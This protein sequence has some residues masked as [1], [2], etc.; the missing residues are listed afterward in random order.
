MSNPLISLII[1]PQKKQNLT[2]HQFPP[3]LPSTTHNI[4]TINRPE[5][6]FSCFFSWCNLRFHYFDEPYFLCSLCSWIYFMWLTDMLPWPREHI[7]I[8]EEGEVRSHFI[9]CSRR[10]Y[11]RTFRSL[12]RNSMLRKSIGLLSTSVFF[13]SLSFA[14]NFMIFMW[15]SID[16]VSRLNSLSRFYEI[17]PV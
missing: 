12:M 8:Y 1:A 17:P 14:R 11:L 2:C 6:S 9:S 5:N 4:C 16:A 13:P 15:E 3:K 10:K 7:H